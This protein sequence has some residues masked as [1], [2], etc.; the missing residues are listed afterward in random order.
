M[1]LEV[2][3]LE[4]VY[5]GYCFRSRLEARWAVAMDAIQIAY[6]YEPEGFQ[7]AGSRYLPDFYLPKVRFFAEVKPRPFNYYERRKA[8]EL[9]EATA[10]PVLMLDGAPDFRTYDAIHCAAIDGGDVPEVFDYLLDVDYHGRRHY[11]EGRLFG[12]TGGWFDAPEHFSQ[13]YQDAVRSARTAR[14]DESGRW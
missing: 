10:C 2:K 1:T 8:F 4:T 9:A 3:A 13:Q 7:L 14:F 6:E 12:G 11:N 5:R